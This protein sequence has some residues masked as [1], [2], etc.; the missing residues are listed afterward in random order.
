MGE[1]ER[2]GR[3]ARGGGGAARRAARSAVRFDTAK[4]IE[5]EHAQSGG[6][7]RRGDRDHRAQCRNGA[8]G[9][10]RRLRREPRRA[11]PLARGGRRC[12]RASACASRAALP[13]SCAKP[14]PRHSPRSRATRARRGDRRQVPRPRAGLRPPV[15]PRS[16]WRSALCH[17]GRFRNAGETG[18]HVRMAAPFRRHGVRAHRRAREQ[19]PFRHALRAYAAFRQ[20]VHGLGHRTLARGDSVEMAKILFG[21]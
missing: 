15:L 16:R 10:R 5:R 13:A 1:A 2:A 19:A 3:R 9:D 4:F 14:R 12:R 8:G 18:L 6:P 20:T 17:D 21:A 7:E 11:G